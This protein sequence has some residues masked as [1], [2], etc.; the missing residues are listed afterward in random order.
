MQD[1]VLQW[2]HGYPYFWMQVLWFG[3]FCLL[4]LFLGELRTVALWG[5]LLML[6]LLPTFLFFEG[7]YWSPIRI[8]GLVLGIEDPLCLFALGSV[9]TACGFIPFR[10]RISIN[11]RPHQVILRVSTA[12]L[13]AV[14][15][16][17]FL[18]AGYSAHT[19]CLLAF[20]GLLLLVLILRHS[21]WHLSLIGALSF[22]T[23]GCVMLWLAFW[24]WP[25]FEGQWSQDNW[26]G[27]RIA[28][29]PLGEVIW[30]ACFGAS[31]PT[32]VAWCFDGFIDKGV[33]DQAFPKVRL[34]LYR[35]VKYFRP[36]SD[37]R[38]YV[39]ATHPNQR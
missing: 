33:V 26:W 23:L 13:G 14:L 28:G 5:G 34:C 22:S 9:A 39:L 7:N 32:W 15:F 17:L 24:I 35:I 16:C 11:T 36:K 19:A 6:P 21:L 10:S 8:G 38:R 3:V 31:Y 37:S 29:L 1:Q 27:I 4:Y 20:S 30:A 2:W 18:M 25:Q 12:V